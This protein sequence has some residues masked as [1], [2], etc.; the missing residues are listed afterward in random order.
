MANDMIRLS[1]IAHARSGDK[2]SGANVGIIA[3][4]PQ[5]FAF[6]RDFL[7]AD[8]VESF[9]APLGVGKVTRYDLPNLGA[10][11]FVLPAILAGGGSR[12]VRTDA[13]GKTLGQVLLEME[14]PLPAE[15][16]PACVRQS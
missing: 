3:Y 13:Q 5:G 9:F 12:S 11:N 1:E 16:L 10:F 14:I 8:R 6:L 4:T 7:T 15:A 2:G